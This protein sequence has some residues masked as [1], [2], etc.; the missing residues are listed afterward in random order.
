M[1]SRQQQ[2]AEA[3]ERRIAAER[4]REA[5]EKRKRLL[6]LGG[7]AVLIV[8]A[9]VA[10]VI[11]AGGGDS[12]DGGETASDGNTPADSANIFR[13]IPQ[14]GTSLGDPKADQVLTEYADLQCPFCAEYSNNVLP[15]VVEKYVRTGRVR[16]E[17]RLLRFVGPDSDRGAQAA[18]G[19]AENDRMGQFVE[20]WYRN[21]GTENSGYAD[22]DFIR[23]IAEE[24]G[25]PP[26]DAIQAAGS[27][28][29]SGPIEEVE[30]E[31][32]V[33][34]ID[35][36][37]SFVIG[38]EAGQGDRLEVDELTFEAFDDVLG[39]VLGTAGG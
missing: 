22:D 12:D 34:G 8:A 32:D 1:S 30:Q 25:V 16:L 39:D 38:P 31:A 5:A 24:A 11:V 26:E 29:K 35:S 21:Q 10:I 19:A 6:R 3:R 2:K 4:E 28:S 27:G 20:A 17:L 14:N 18:Q 23:K 13:G 33:L 9:I 15:Q 7:A 37:P 36:T